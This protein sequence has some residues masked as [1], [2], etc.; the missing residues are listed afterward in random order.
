MS[1]HLNYQHFVPN[2]TWN[3]IIKD[4]ASHIVVYMS[5]QVVNLERLSC[6]EPGIKDKNSIWPKG[7][8]RQLIIAGFKRCEY[9][10]CWTFKKHCHVEPVGAVGLVLGERR[11]WKTGK[12]FARIM[13]ALLKMHQIHDEKSFGASAII[14]TILEHVPTMFFF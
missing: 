1:H 9:T 4:L 5:K 2:K 3:Q 12:M 13:R 8:G 11:C 10:Y 7:S 14:Q 6:G